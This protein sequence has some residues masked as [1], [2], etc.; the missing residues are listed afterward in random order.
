MTDGTPPPEPLAADPAAGTDAATPSA[1]AKVEAL[2]VIAAD[3]TRAPDRG[4]KP[5]WAHLDSPFT[6]GLLLTL[7]GL[8]AILLGI[9]VT[10]I[11]TVIIYIALAMFAALGLDPV[12][13][14]LGR[15]NVSRT[16]S[17][18][19]I[20]LILF[21]VG[22]GLLVLVIPTLV[23]Q[24]GQ[25]ITSIPSTVTSFQTT[26][27][28]HWLEGIFG[29]GLTD[30]IT[31]VQKFLTT[32]SNI[33]AISGGI[34]K[35]GAG[36]ATAVSGGLIIIVLTLYFVA[37]LPGIKES[38]TQFAPA[39]NRA[40]VRDMT[41][42]ITDSVGGY[43]MGMVILAFFNSIVAFLLHLFL[44][45]PYPLLMGVLAF[46]ITIIPLVGPVLYWVAASILALFT[47]PL[48]ALI[49][50]IAY[51]IYIQIEAY[52]I[53]PRVMSKAISIPGSLVVIGALIGGT[54]LGLLGA[55][56]AVP[57]AASIL[58]IIKQVFIPRQDAKL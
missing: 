49:F 16:W 42:Q 41:N 31:E 29:T 12:I 1:Q 6:V 7:G 40:K 21:V 55:L 58:L 39:R 27:F 24:V 36:I 28:Y 48:S 54:L 25:F 26:D 38:L 5:F 43:L 17:I 34:L 33:A 51:L 32:P 23:T 52:V 50:A 14:M 8:V 45:L 15:H 2:D 22:G 4:G 44:G 57:V 11:A 3:A 37:S 13:K 19:I 47:S 20:F 10:N 9:A 46:C 53:T 35:V 30:L 56:I 18:V